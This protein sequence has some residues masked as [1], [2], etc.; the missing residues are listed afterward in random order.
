MA[1]TIYRAVRR[2][3]GNEEWTELTEAAVFHGRIPEFVGDFVNVHLP[4]KV[5]V[6]PQPAELSASKAEVSKLELRVMSM[7]G[8]QG[9]VRGVLAVPEDYNLPDHHLVE[10]I[11]AK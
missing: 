3:A 4:S 9:D 5:A 7:L 8:P 11:K 10:I 6:S 1:E 2:K